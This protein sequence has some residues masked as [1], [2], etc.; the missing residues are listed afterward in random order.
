MR[1]LQGVRG[2]DGHLKWTVLK[3]LLAHFTV[4]NGLI[5]ASGPISDSGHIIITSF[6][7]PWALS[8]MN[9]I[10]ACSFFFPWNPWITNFFTCWTHSTGQASCQNLRLT[11]PVGL[12]TFT[13]CKS[14]QRNIWYESDGNNLIIWYG[15]KLDVTLMQNAR[16]KVDK[17]YSD[18]ERLDIGKAFEEWRHCFDFIAEIEMHLQSQDL[19][20]RDDGARAHFSAC[21]RCEHTNAMQRIRN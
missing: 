7:S 10:N 15:T 8:P 6:S 9:L 18:M 17:F 14:N 21:L 2:E 20:A 12:R 13:D 1:K 3:S 5:I 19:D 11:F 16:W 4:V